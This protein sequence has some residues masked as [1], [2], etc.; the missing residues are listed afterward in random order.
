MSPK[1]LYI[2]L[3]LTILILLACDKKSTNPEPQPVDLLARIQNL[4][5]VEALEITPLPG[6]NRAFLWCSTSKS[7]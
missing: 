4:P 2:F 7:V 6:F 3:F 1:D 5:G